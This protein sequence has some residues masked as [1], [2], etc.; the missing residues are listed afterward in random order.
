MV[1]YCIGIF[2]GEFMKTIASILFKDIIDKNELKKTAVATRCC[3]GLMI[4]Y[5]VVFAILSGI[6]GS[7]HGSIVVCSLIV[8]YLIALYMTYGKKI[9]NACR[10]V[11]IVTLI[12][13]P[14]TVLWFGWNSGIQHF[15]FALVL[16]NILFV[17]MSIKTQLL[18]VIGVCAIRLSL[19]FHC[20]YYVPMYQ[21]SPTMSVIIQV[22]STVFVFAFITVCGINYALENQNTENT[23]RKY[24]VE[25]QKIASTDPLTQLWNRHKMIEHVTEY[26]SETDEFCSLC[27]CDIDFFKKIN[28]TYGHEAGDK[29]LVALSGLF[30]DEMR[31]QGVVAR[32]GGE[33]FLLGFQNVNG[34]DA[35]VSLSNLRTKVKKLVVP[36]EGQDIQFTMTFGLVEYDRTLTLDENIKIADERLYRGKQN[37]RDQIVY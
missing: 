25:L 19:Y 33:E 28:D 13:I 21:F 8:G 30:M 11:D 12:G 15:L 32:W 34:D 27:L 23:I 26:L 20:K 31:K 4:I 29:V 1:K 10:A 3:C 9:Q 14:I 22:I 37:G 6:D 16:F 36:Y 17:R 7:I 2:C 35:L 18:G 24:N 5:A